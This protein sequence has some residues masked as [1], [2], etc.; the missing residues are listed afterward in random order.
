MEMEEEQEKVKGRERWKEEYGRREEGRV[1]RKKESKGEGEMNG[2][3][4]GG[5]ETDIIRVAFVHPIKA[6][7]FDFFVKYTVVISLLPTVLLVDKC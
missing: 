7:F 3:G 6:L 1:V 4:E 2:E 5:M